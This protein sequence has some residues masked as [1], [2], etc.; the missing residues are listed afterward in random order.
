MLKLTQDQAIWLLQLSEKEI[1][2]LFA[3]IR[4]QRLETLM[5]AKADYEQGKAVQDEIAALFRI[6]NMVLENRRA[7]AKDE[8][9]QEK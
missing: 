5:S 8:E 9:K 4:A 3:S 2:K 6:E 1:Q 7:A